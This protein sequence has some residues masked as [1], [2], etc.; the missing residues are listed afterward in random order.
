MVVLLLENSN[1]ASFASLFW[2]GSASAPCDLHLA[3]KVNMNHSFC[4][5]DSSTVNYPRMEWLKPAVG[6][7]CH[8]LAISLLLRHFK[9]WQMTN[10]TLPHTAG[11]IQVATRSTLFSTSPRWCLLEQASERWLLIYTGTYQCH[12]VT[13]VN[14]S[15]KNQYFLTKQRDC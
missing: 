14:I 6:C 11:P 5:S 8:C 15:P 13:E 12:R 9:C 10:E 4:C 2:E 3:T 1:R 7:S